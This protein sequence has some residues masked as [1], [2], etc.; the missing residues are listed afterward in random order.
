MQLP[1]AQRNPLGQT[2]PKQSGDTQVEPPQ[3]SP[4]AHGV[5]PQDV[6]WQAPA[7]PAH[8]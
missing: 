7:A 2:T 4:L 8:R 6:G 5:D 1:A 3:T